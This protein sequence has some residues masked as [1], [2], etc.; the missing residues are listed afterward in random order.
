MHNFIT[1]KTDF[2]KEKYNIFL[3]S[4]EDLLKLC[5]PAR[6]SEEVRLACLVELLQRRLI[7]PQNVKFV[8]FNDFLSD[9]EWKNFTLLFNEDF[10]QTIP[11]EEKLKKSF[12]QSE[13]EFSEK[14][15]ILLRKKLIDLFCHTDGFIPVYLNNKAFFIPFHYETGTSSICNINGE[16]I[17]EWQEKYQLA[18]K[19]ESYKCVLHCSLKS[20]ELTGNSFMLPLYLALQR[21]MGHLQYNLLQLIA[22]GAIENNKLCAVETK[23]KALAVKTHFPHACFFFPENTNYLPLE[24]NEIPLP[25]SITLE[26]TIRIIAENV[27]A[28]NLYKPSF[29]EALNRLQI[30]DDERI[31]TYNKWEIMLERI[32]N[33]AKAI[34]T[35][36][37]PENHLLCMMLKSAVHCHMG[38][39]IEA[40]KFNQK[41]KEFAVSNGFEKQLRRLEIEELVEFQ[42]QEK[43]DIVAE[44][45]EPLKENI[46]K[47]E[48]ADL[49][50]RYYGTMGQAHSY[51]YLAHKKYYSKETAKKY[52]QLALKYANITG[53]E[54]DIAQ[55]LNYNLL[56]YAL[57]EPYNKDAEILQEDIAEHIKRNLDGNIQCKNEYFFRRTKAF[58]L[59]RNYLSSGQVLPFDAKD[60][61]LPSEADFWLNA[62]TKKYVGALF[63]AAGKYD[64]ARQL[65]DDAIEIMKNK[66]YHI[67]RFIYMT[68]LA[69]AYHSLGEEKYQ[70]DALQVIDNLK[71]TYPDSVP[72]WRNFLLGTDKFPGMN[73]WY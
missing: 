57:F 72:A 32:E 35:Y 43:F 24:E 67:L 26:E 4:S 19:N 65:F 39:S 28:K 20:E 21:K 12:W 38:N 70:K 16:I 11:N 69:E 10:L 46:E 15:Q 41:A 68:I 34:P 22:T 58:L 56:W 13:N 14:C 23:Q 5:N 29:R 48:D 1:L 36:R 6:Y 7:S 50:M 61:L 8:P 27:E 2:E 49:L 71:E 63:A 54:A 31:G 60:I 64:V 62:V 18:V 25:V 55:D 40:L 52:F 47:L 9:N 17:T 73:Y 51:G 33:N 42:D 53:S 44:L 45:A 3:Y 59:Y 66:Y 30:I 37:D